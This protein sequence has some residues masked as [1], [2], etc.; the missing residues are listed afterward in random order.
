[1]KG[2]YIEF[3]KYIPGEI[4]KEPRFVDTPFS[5]HLTHHFVRIFTLDQSLSLIDVSFSWMWHR[6]NMFAHRIKRISF[7]HDLLQMIRQKQTIN[8]WKTYSDKGR[9]FNLY[10]NK[11]KTYILGCHKGL[12]YIAVIIYN[13][14]EREKDLF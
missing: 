14:T 10:Q 7:C 5:C 9:S 2:F 6:H 3:K 12:M 4:G 11:D 8:C 1:M 13:I